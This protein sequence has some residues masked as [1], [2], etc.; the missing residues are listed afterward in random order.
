MVLSGDTIKRLIVEQGLVRDRK[1]MVYCEKLGKTMPYLDYILTNVGP[2]NLDVRVGHQFQEL[3]RSSAGFIDLHSQPEYEPLT[4]DADGAYFIQPGQFIL[5][6]TIEYIKL[7]NN[8]MATIDSRSSIGRRGLVTQTATNIQAGFEGTL[9][10]ELKN[11][12][13]VA[14][15]IC[16]GDIVSQI[17]FEYLDTETS[18]PYNGAYQGQSTTQPPI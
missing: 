8:I 2:N 14:I 9:T 4:C 18:T 15:R 13:P 10:L 16:P 3:K 17:I 12:A 11:E 6:T 7:P 1:E 5:A